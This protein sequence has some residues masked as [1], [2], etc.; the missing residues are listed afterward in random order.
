MSEAPLGAPTVTE[1]NGT[2]EQQQVGPF[3]PPR[4]RP[5]F[6]L[7]IASGLATPPSD[8][9]LSRGH[10]S[11]LHLL[12]RPIPYFALGAWYA[13]RSF[14]WEAQSESGF[15]SPDERARSNTWGGAVRGYPLARRRLEPYV[16]LGLGVQQARGTVDDL[17]CSRISTPV[18]W[19]MGLGFDAHAMPVLRLGVTG[20]VTGL[21]MGGGFGCTMQWIENEPPG[22]PD[23]GIGAALELSATVGAPTSG[24]FVER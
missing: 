17:Q 16:E 13:Y 2:A 9:A 23:S 20:S 22:P 4:H 21:R 3:D 6:E 11:T 14:A 5:W 7:S 8:H 15:H 18:V 10:T 1:D 19:R 24:P 12:V